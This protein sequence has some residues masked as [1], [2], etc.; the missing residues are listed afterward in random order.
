[1]TV[2]WAAAEEQGNPKEETTHYDNDLSW[3]DEIGEFAAAII[4]DEP[5]KSG[6][7]DDALKSMELVYRIYCADTEWRDQWGLRDPA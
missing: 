6:S 1:M 2:A 5:I 3:P 7:S 4:N